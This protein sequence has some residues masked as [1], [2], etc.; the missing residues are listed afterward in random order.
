MNLGVV[1]NPRHAEIREILSRIFAIAQSYDLTLYT[2]PDLV[3]V[4]PSEVPV[5][6]AMNAERGW[7]RP[8]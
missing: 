3:G 4:W 1:G 8:Q 7:V 2:D 5:L 6:D